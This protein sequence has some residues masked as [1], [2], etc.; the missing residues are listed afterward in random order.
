MADP[1]IG[2][3]VDGLREWYYHASL[4]M[5]GRSPACCNRQV[6]ARYRSTS[7]E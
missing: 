5:A 3:R 4:R 7:R 6:A 1:S 2:A